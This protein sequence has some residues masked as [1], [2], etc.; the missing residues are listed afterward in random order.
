[1][2]GVF[3]PK[4][5]ASI[6]HLD[7][8]AQRLME[9]F[10][11]GNHRSPFRGVSTDF[12]EHRHYVPGDDTRHLD[13]KVYARADRF[14][15]KKYEQDTNLKAWMLLD[16]SNSMFFKSEGALMSKYEYAATLL[17]SISYKF[18]K[19]QDAIGLMLFDKDV[20]SMVPPKASFSQFKLMTDTM[21]KAKPGKDTALGE[22]IKKLGM[23]I[24]Q[25]GM[26]ILA[27]DFLDDID[28]LS[29]GLS[30]LNF[31]GN[32]VVL[33][34]IEDPLERSFDFNGQTVFRGLEGEGK[35]NCNPG[36]VKAH[37]LAQRE[38]HIAGLYHA[39]RMQ[40]FFIEQL[41][42]SESLESTLPGILN[43]RSEVRT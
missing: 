37:Y 30:M 32:E 31:E 26:V 28:A 19:Q 21:E 43:T 34:H 39:C 16:C 23:Q 13:W 1:M 22:V 33:L 8:K 2:A 5:I 3:D 27:S 9:G 20:V 15:V 24:K 41:E 29:E 11:L 18:Y 6:D 17:A 40:G 36:D 35:L 10:M 4:A 25:R 42:T 38:E 12:A 14:F 7:I